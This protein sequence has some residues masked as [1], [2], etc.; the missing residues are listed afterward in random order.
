M[1]LQDLLAPRTDPL[2]PLPALRRLWLG[3]STKAS[4]EV[5]GTRLMAE[6]GQRKGYVGQVTGLDCRGQR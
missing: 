4:P 5:M 3:Q 1:G 2:S 6:Q